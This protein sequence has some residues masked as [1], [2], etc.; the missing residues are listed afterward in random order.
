MRTKMI[1]IEWEDNLKRSRNRWERLRYS[2]TCESEPELETK[3][4]TIKPLEVRF[5]R[6]VD[7]RE[8]N[9]RWIGRQWELPKGWERCWFW[10]LNSSPNLDPFDPIFDPLVDDPPS[11]KFSKS[12]SIPLEFWS[13]TQRHSE[14]QGL[15]LSMICFPFEGRKEEGSQKTTEKAGQRNEV[16]KSPKISSKELWSGWWS[17]QK[18][19]SNEKKGDRSEQR[20]KG[21]RLP[22]VD[23]FDS[24]WWRS[25][26]NLDWP[27][28]EMHPKETS[29]ILNRKNQI[30]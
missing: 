12:F 1:W 17:V 22:L 28:K 14:L 7:L 24:T 6:A 29:R 20:W 23:W 19:A 13:Q 8:W 10:E 9:L 2:W 26:I 25:E 4:L 16:W 30:C 27:V 5:E 15:A 11:S 21:H 18:V 3:G